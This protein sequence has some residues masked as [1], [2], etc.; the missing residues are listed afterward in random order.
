MSRWCAL[1]FVVPE[2]PGAGKLHR[3][4]CGT[5]GQLAVLPLWRALQAEANIPEQP[6]A[7]KPLH[8]NRISTWAFI[9]GRRL[10]SVGSSSI[11]KV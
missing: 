6:G 5:V 2:Q 10:R 9:P 11:I 7:R 4:L 8:S 1:Q 3:A